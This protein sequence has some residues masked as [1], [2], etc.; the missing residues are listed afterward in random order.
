MSADSRREEANERLIL[1]AFV[2]WQMGAGGKSTFG[3]YLSGLGLSGEAP[4]PKAVDQGTA[5]A[6]LKRMGIMEEKR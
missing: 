5:D 3:D 6:K 4:Q 2:G 1:A